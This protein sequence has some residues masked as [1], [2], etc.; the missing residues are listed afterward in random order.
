MEI[1]NLDAAVTTA[2]HLFYAVILVLL[3]LQLHCMSK[4]LAKGHA[5][6]NHTDDMTL[7]GIAWA[8]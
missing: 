3:L 5:L 4:T 7:H 1:N 8:F 6:A 2:A